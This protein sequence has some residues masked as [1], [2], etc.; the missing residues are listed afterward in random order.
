MVMGVFGFRN[1]EKET[2]MTQAQKVIAV[3]KDGL[4]DQLEERLG[5]DVSN[6]QLFAIR[7]EIA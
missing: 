1:R 5:Q 2:K 4:L 6:Q 7:F 3:K